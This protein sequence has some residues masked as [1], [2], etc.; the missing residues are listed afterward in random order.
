MPSPPH[1]HPH[2]HRHPP[3]FRALGPLV[4]ALKFFIF[5]ALQLPAKYK[6]SSNKGKGDDNSEKKELE[7]ISLA[8][9]KELIEAQRSKTTATTSGGMRGK[10]GARSSSSRGRTSTAAADRAKKSSGTLGANGEALPKR[11]MTG[12]FRFC[13][14]CRRSAA[15]ASGARLTT[16][17]LTER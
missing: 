14:D 13:S 6:R 10:G 2:L 9:A 17:E 4:Y 1:P 16:S 8:E 11:P 5:Y 15:E 7:Q 12:F 3:H